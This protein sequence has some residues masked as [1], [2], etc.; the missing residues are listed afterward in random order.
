MFREQRIMAGRGVGTKDQIISQ[1]EDTPNNAL[2]F[3]TKTKLNSLL[4]TF[5]SKLFLFPPCPS[6]A[7]PFPLT[8][9]VQRA[10]RCHCTMTGRM[11]IMM[12]WGLHCQIAMAAGVQRTLGKSRPFAGTSTFHVPLSKRNPLAALDA[13]SAPSTCRMANGLLRYACACCWMS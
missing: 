9:Y 4:G 5:F 10:Q 8:R 3:R 2:P 7:L 13:P 12:L 1:K 11:L 6:L